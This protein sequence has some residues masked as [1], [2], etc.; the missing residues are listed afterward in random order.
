VTSGCGSGVYLKGGRTEA[1]EREKEEG[2]EGK[3]GKENEGE[4]E[5]KKVTGKKE[6]EKETPDMHMITHSIPYTSTRAYTLQ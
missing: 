4:T 6:T 3:T 5:R 1:E 2:R